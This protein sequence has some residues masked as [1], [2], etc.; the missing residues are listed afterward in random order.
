M[1]LLHF[2]LP[3]QVL[4]AEHSNIGSQETLD[5]SHL[6]RKSTDGWSTVWDITAWIIGPRCRPPYQII[7]SISYPFQER[8]VLRHHQSD[9]DPFRK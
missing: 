4:A 3:F 8:P 9:V 2:R 6:V 1:R 5:Q 7:L